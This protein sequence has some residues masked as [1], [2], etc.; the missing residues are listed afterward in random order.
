MDP[1]DVL[2]HELCH[3]V[4]RG[5]LRKVDKMGGFLK[6]IHHRKKVVVAI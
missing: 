2:H 4:S 5:Q 6:S 3:L 1:E